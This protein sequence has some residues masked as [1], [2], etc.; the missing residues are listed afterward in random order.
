MNHCQPL[1]SIIIAIYNVEKYLPECLDSI[2]KQTYENIEIIAV[3]DGSTDGCGEIIEHY[4]AKD[5]RVVHLKQVN[6]GIPTTKAN[7]VN[8]SKGDYVMFVDGDDFIP[9]SAIEKIVNRALECNAD[10]VYTDYMD[11]YSDNGVEVVKY[12]PNNVDIRNGIEFLESMVSTFIWMKLIKKEHFSNLVR[13]SVNVG[14]DCFFLLQ[15][16]PKC[17]IVSYVEEPLYY[18]RHHPESI[19][20]RQIS[21]IVNE[22][23]IHS[24]ER[25]NLVKTLQLTSKIKDDLIYDNVHIIFRYLRYGDE[26]MKYKNIDKLIN[27][28][29]KNFPY[30]RLRNLHAVKLMLYLFG[31]KFAPKFTQKISKKIII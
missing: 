17:K 3:N 26:Y 16:L 25:N 4:V 9:P 20:N 18:Y 31:A 15:I 2:S 30:K 5:S 7:G 23:L 11:L 22:W 6:S 14:D 28:T 12:N 27:I 21:L 24:L 1:V 10:F 29:Y 19:M 13:Q 8:F